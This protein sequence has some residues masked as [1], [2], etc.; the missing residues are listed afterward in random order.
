MQSF[1]YFKVGTTYLQINVFEIQYIQADRR[2]VLVFT[3]AHCYCC[4]ASIAEIEHQLPPAMFC[5]IHRSYIISLAHTSKFDN[6]LAYVSGRKLPI[7]RQYRNVLRDAI[8]VV[9]G[10]RGP[11]ELADGDVERLLRHVGP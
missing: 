4:R 6:D 10:D 8:V 2:T 5:R 3:R 9:N 7:A 11:I 1:F